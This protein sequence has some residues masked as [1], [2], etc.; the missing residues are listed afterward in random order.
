MKKVTRNDIANLL[1]ISPS[2]VTRALNDHKATSEETKKKVM[3]LAEEMGYIPSDLG[4]SFYQNKSFRLGVLIPYRKMTGGIHSI[5][6]EHL[7]IFL[8]G[9]I[10]SASTEEYTITNIADT[11]LDAKFLENQVLSKKIDGVILLGCKSQDHRP[12]YLYKK[13][14]PFILIHHYVE[15]RPFLFIES[16]P[17]IGYAELFDHLRKKNV[18]SIGFLSGGDDFVDAVDRKRIV[19]R[20][21][22]E[23]NMKVSRIIEGDFSLQSGL[24]AANQFL[25]QKLP[26]VVICAN[27]N[28]AFG[29]ME[30]F[31][32]K[33]VSIP[34]D[35]GVT[36]FDNFELSNFITPKLTTINNPFYE[37]GLLAANM[38][39][40]QIKGDEVK[41]RKFPTHLVVRESA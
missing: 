3:Q 37:I 34:G 35:V 1:G 4:R 8:Y 22:E 25:E 15:N 11:G 16:D 39:I 6:H 31:K 21:A 30:G 33:E 23:N 41:S 28:M 10:L 40:A 27:D 24:L 7:T 32:K 26:E 19:V 5:T 14:V 38:L 12:H 18:R 13:K 29:L 9:L 36:G 17:E 20:L 2:T